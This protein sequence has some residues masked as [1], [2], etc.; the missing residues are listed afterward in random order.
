MSGLLRIDL[1]QDSYQVM[2]HVD[3]RLSG[4]CTAAVNGRGGCRGGGKVLGFSVNS[5]NIVCSSSCNEILTWRWV[6]I[7]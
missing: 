3:D 4:S 6:G 7:P 5:G 2:Y 1:I